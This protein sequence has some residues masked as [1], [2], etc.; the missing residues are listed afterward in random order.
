MVKSLI[1]QKNLKDHKMTSQNLG[2]KEY[3]CHMES[4]IITNFYL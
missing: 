3:N 2:S 1:V 4:V